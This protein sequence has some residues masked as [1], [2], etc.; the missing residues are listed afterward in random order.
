[1]EIQEGISRYF[2]KTPSF[3]VEFRETN[4]ALSFI[5]YGPLDLIC[6][7]ALQDFLV[8]I[9]EN[10][11]L[12]TCLVLDLSHV[13]YISSTGVGAL[14]QALMA[15]RKRDIRFQLSN[16][17]PKVRSVF[18]LLGLMDFFEEADANG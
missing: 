8:W 16:L 10:Q 11:D 12:H 15:A 14:T 13:E 7:Q 2:G 5:L 1:M 6:S 18:V 17:T 3:R 9:I 4:S